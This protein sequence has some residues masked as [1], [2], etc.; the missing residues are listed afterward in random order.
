MS[1]ILKLVQ[2]TQEWHDHRAKS[3]NASETPAVL[4]VSP[5]QTPY[6]LWLLK[7]GRSEQKVTPAMTRGTE[8]EPAARAAYEVQTGHIMEPLVLT[9]GPYSASL[10]GITLAGDLVL[11]NQQPRPKGRGMKSE[12]LSNV[13]GKPRGIRPREIKCPWKGRDS[14]L[15]KAVQLSQVPDYYGW[16][17]EHQLMVAGA[18]RT[19]LWVFDGTEGLL[20]EVAAR[21]ERWSEI[22]KAW[23]KFVQFLASDTPPPLTERDTRIREDQEWREA[24]LKYLE[25]KQRSEVHA[26]ILDEAKAALVALTSHPSESG[27]GVSVSSFWKRGN[28]EYKKVPALQG[29]NLEKFRGASRMETRVSVG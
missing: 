29:V 14:D 6:E 23:D 16:Q 22:R 10:D 12:L 3:R 2:G 27:Y 13:R 24:A 17:I 7:T 11:E 21:P 15:W 8:L 20:L 1:A 25:A 28:V 4:G 5:W 19:H 9:D 26:T 18:R